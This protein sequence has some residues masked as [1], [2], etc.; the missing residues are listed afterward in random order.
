LIVLAFSLQDPGRS[1]A[2]ELSPPGFSAQ[3]AIVFANQA[4]ENYGAR[5][6]GT[7]QDQRL[8]DLVEARF[9]SVGFGPTRDTF[10]ATTLNGS[11]KLVN[12]TGVRPGPSDRRLVVIASRDG[13]PGKL[14]RT[15]AIE[16]GMLLELA[17]AL[18][19]RAF[20]HSIVLAS[21]SG[22]VDGGLGAA[23]FAK[24]LNGQVD[25]VI[26]LRNVG[27]GPDGPA[28][29]SRFDGRLAPDQ[30]FEKTVE[31]IAGLELDRRPAEHGLPAQLV[32]L[33][34]P[35]ALGEQASLPTDGLTAT[36][37]SPGG[38]PLAPPAADAPQLTAQSGQAM[39]RT[40]T[41]LDGDFRPDPPAAAPLR[42]G[43]KLIPQWALVLFIGSL[44]FPLVVAAIDGW[45]RA[46]RWAQPSQRGLIAPPIAF[47][48]L[49]LIALLLRAVALT[50]VIDAPPL[51]PDPAAVTG[52][53]PS[54][55]G[56]FTAVLAAIGVLV[57]TAAARQ[58]TPKGGE[59]GFALWIT[60]AG[61]AVFVVNPVAAGFL[62]LLLHLVVLTLLTGGSGRRQLVALVLLGLLPVI[63]A[64]VYYPAV[65]DISALG[66][67]GYGVLLESG[68][69]VG[70]FA[71]AA[72][73]AVVAAVGTA[74][75]QLFWTAPKRPDPS[76][77]SRRSPFSV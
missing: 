31:R 27:G 67:I 44:L 75:I 32:R 65:L 18:E 63:G 42:I 1:V 74:V 34:F 3:R 56:I 76:A 68:G 19:G 36:A 60:F 37:L 58:A 45:A 7:V 4:V 21:V 10:D 39:L 20:D 40:L 72:G 16:T 77:V 26:V 28:V 59:A 62:I 9:E 35:L 29:L 23:E 43:G 17:R 57:A 52:A 12:I 71:V 5:E 41:T 55:I 66:S 50:G 14:K 25:G 53:G 33:G 51:P 64:I 22:G 30:R 70:P 47:V 11:R 69:Y 49:L 15:G 46:R 38:E 24:T 54:V 6:S 13:S 61:I 73:C 48:W 8:A 2:P